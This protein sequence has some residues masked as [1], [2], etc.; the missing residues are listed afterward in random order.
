[1]RIAGGYPKGRVDGLLSLQRGESEMIKIGV[2][3]PTWTNER[4]MR[5]LKM[6]PSF[7]PIVKT[8]NNIYD[9][10]AFTEELIEKC[11]VLLFSGFAPYSISKDKIPKHIPAHYVPVKGA[12]LYRALYKLQKRVKQ[13]QKLSIDTLSLLE[14][15]QIKK[16]IGEDFVILN[17][18]ENLSLAKTEE[19]IEFH[20]KS[21]RNHHADCILTGLKIVSDRLTE[22]GIPN[23][24]LRPTEE[25]IIVTLERALLSTEQRKKKESQFVFGII[26]LENVDQI[27]RKSV[28]EQH[29]QRLFIEVQKSILDFVEIIEGHLTMLNGNEYMFVTT[30]GTFERVTEGYKYFPL[31]QELKK[32]HQVLISVGVGFGTSANEAGTHARM[33]LMQAI[34]FGGQQCFIVNDNRRVIGPIE[35][36]APITYPLHITDERLIKQAEKSSISPYY[37]MKVISIIDRK[38]VDTFTAHEL[39][40]SLGVTTRSAHRILSSWLD[41][42]IVEIVGIE[43]LQ[44]KG[45]PR[46]IYKLLV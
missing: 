41:A 28:S 26:Q 42:E 10:P 27:K 31:I 25:D 1:M 3:G 2:V 32:E 13:I 24:W 38:N 34:D 19:I 5:S 12:S 17:Y 8:S 46:Q 20:E 33:A 36:E 18:G 23:E 30:R 35:K 44:K 9:A 22:K 45:R 37:L 7:K 16:E 15:E 21:Y 11:E 40:S 29:I 4:I 6:F 43:K 39:A 14:I